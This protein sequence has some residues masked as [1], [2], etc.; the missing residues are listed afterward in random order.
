ML[1]GLR[2]LWALFQLKL[3]T[4]GIIKDVRVNGYKVVKNLDK[5]NVE[6]FLQY[7]LK[8]EIKPELFNKPLDCPIE[9]IHFVWGHT[10]LLSHLCRE[11]TWVYRTD[12]HVFSSTNPRNTL[13]LYLDL[14]DLQSNKEEIRRAI[15]IEDFGN[16]I[17]VYY[18]DNCQNY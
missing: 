13:G 7:K 11:V 15:I 4:K 10:I 6:E 2:K 8:D 16:T 18:L 3:Y 1:N 5:D 17:K 14:E 12:N 9:E